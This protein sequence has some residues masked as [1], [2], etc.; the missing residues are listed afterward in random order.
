M[1]ARDSLP[2]HGQ[3]SRNGGIANPQEIRN[4]RKGL[5]ALAESGNSIAYFGSHHRFATKLRATTART[6]RPASVRSRIRSRSNSP[7]APMT[8]EQHFAYRGDCFGL[9]LKFQSQRLPRVRTDDHVSVTQPSSPMGQSC[10]CCYSKEQ[11]NSVG[12]TQFGC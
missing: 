7:T 6:C 10:R 4:V 11:P 12:P 2:L 3:G 8:N 5:A 9:T 1:R